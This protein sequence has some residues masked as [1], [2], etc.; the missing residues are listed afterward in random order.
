MHLA[1]PRLQ[2]ERRL[3]KGLTLP[4]RGFD[5]KHRLV[6]RELHVEVRDVG[7]RPTVA[8]LLGHEGLREGADADNQRL[9]LC[10]AL[11]V[12]AAKAQ[13][14]CLLDRV[15]HDLHRERRSRLLRR[16]VHLEPYQLLHGVVVVHGK[17]YCVAAFPPRALV[18]RQPHPRVAHYVAW[19]KLPEQARLHAAMRA[20]SVGPIIRKLA[21]QRELR[22]I[23]CF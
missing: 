21:L 15:L 7:L 10:G 16:V 18:N 13:A 11:L 9:E 20:N 4:R 17:D 6:L 22:R 14:L 23:L 5:S 1:Q 12:V 19:S 3:G 8:R 2:R